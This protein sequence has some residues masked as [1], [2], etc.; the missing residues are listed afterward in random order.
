MTVSHWVR[1]LARGEKRCE[2]AVLGAGVAGLSAAIRLAQRGV[3]H[4]VIERHAPGAGASTR[5][6][7]F[8]MRGA[9]VNYARA[10]QR[11]GRGTARDVWRRSEE[12]LAALLELGAGSLETFQRVPSCLL[13]LGEDERSECERSM[14]LLRDDGFEAEWAEEGG[15]SAWASGLPLGGLVNPRDGAVNPAEL[16]GML[17]GLVGDRVARG[18]EVFAIRPHE[19]GVAIETSGGLIVAKQALCCLNA[20]AP[21]LLPSLEGLVSPKRGQMLALRAPGARLDMSYYINF[22]S[23]Y[24]RQTSDGSIVLGGCRA[25]FAQEEVGCDDTTTRPVQRALEAFARRLFPSGFDVA[26]RWAGTMGFSRD[27]LPLIGPVEVEGVE[28]GRVWFCGGF[29]GHGMSL[30]NRCAGEAVDAMLDGREP[31]FPISREPAG[32]AHV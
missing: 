13:A 12:N 18:S 2:I 8:L 31:F 21:A 19:R 11:W 24:V 26:A 27:G 17:T 32:A 16:I 7:G 3:D 20:F 30:A 15:D 10:I 25:P 9:D 4:L 5:N 1:T 28:R 23:E 14:R 22:G 6:A 29:T